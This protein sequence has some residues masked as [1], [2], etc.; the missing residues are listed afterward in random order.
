MT[1]VPERYLGATGRITAGPAEELV[2]AGYER[3][4]ADNE[5]LA[6]GMGLADLAHVLSLGANGVIAPDQERT[7]LVALR[8][9]DERD[10]ASLADARYGDL[11][12]LRE[13]WLEER[14]GSAGGWLAAGRPRREAGRIAFR[15]GL[16]SL[17]LDL[18]E[19]VARFVGALV[20]QAAR[21]RATLM[22]DF[23]Y[24]QVAQPTTVGHWM[25]SCAAP[26]L[27]DAERLRADFSWVNASTAGAGGVNGSRVPVDRERL[28]RELGFTSVITHTRDAMGQAEGLV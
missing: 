6:A 17:V 1:E 3:E 27:R 18:E 22:P 7:L 12:N 19:A 15:V 20:E 2:S 14:I 10:P 26:A 16:R 9:L 23:T 28:A 4:L 25:L 11:Y 24:L 5:L 21:H 8:E 13:R